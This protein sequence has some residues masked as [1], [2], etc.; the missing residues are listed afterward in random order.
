VDAAACGGNAAGTSDSPLAAD[1]GDAAGLKRAEAH[2]EKA[3]TLAPQDAEG[4]AARGY[5]RNLYAWDWAGAE[6]DFTKALLL[7]PA[8]GGVQAQYANLLGS[9]GRL[10]EAIAVAQKATKLDP[11]WASGWDA[12]GRYQIFGRDFPSADE[13]LRRALEIQP[14]LAYA[15]SHMGTLQ[16][17]ED[18]AAQALATCRKIDFEVLRLTCIA[19]AEH[20]LVHSKESQQALEELIAKHGKEAAYQIAEV[21]AWRGEKTEAFEWLERAYQQRDGGLSDVKVDVLLAGLHGDPRFEALLR[22]M[23]LPV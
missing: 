10:P 1:I 14:E 23:N 22:K 17:L 8:A 4:Y 16:L 11:L 9:L 13:A 7:E 15:L 2:A 18:N 12:L 3:V 5:L 6:A 20:T 21:F 19:M